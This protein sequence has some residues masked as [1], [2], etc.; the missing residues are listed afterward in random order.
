MFVHLFPISDVIALSATVTSDCDLTFNL[1][2]ACTSTSKRLEYVEKGSDFHDIT[3]L[4][5]SYHYNK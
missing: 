1:Y 3:K 5:M 2:L 4:M